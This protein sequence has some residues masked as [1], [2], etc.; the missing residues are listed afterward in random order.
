MTTPKFPKIKVERA[1][2]EGLPMVAIATVSQVMSRNNVSPH[3]IADFR[4]DAFLT[5]RDMV[6]VIAEYVSLV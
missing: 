4:N 5:D 1:A 6:E 3:T 2:C